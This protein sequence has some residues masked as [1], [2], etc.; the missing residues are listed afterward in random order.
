MKLTR[1]L[2]IPMLDTDAEATGDYVPIDLSTVFEFDWNANTETYGYICN[3]NDTNEVTGYA[4][5]MAQE[6]VLD[7]S[8]PMYKFLYPKF[9]S[10]PTGSDCNIPCLLVEPDMTTGKPTVGRL[11]SDASVVPDNLNTV[12]GKLAFTLNLNGDPVLGTVAKADGKVT[13]TPDATE[14]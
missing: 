12:D 1:N 4:P 14:G 6:I 9:M 3:K 7:N 5:T 13:F 11:W 10:M 8:N 2:Y